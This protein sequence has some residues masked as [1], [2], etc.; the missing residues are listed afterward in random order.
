M[1]EYQESGL[2]IRLKEKVPI[3]QLLDEVKKQTGTAQ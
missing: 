1:S 2:V 3:E